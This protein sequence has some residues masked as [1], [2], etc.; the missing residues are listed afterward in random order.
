MI[1]L[2]PFMGSPIFIDTWKRE[3]EKKR[4]IVINA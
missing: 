4:G 3:S 2:G 1:S